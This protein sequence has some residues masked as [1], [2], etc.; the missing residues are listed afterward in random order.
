[1]ATELNLTSKHNECPPCLSLGDSQLRILFPRLVL[2]CP[3]PEV[4]ANGTTL[5]ETMR[6]LEDQHVGHGGHGSDALDLPQDF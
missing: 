4:G 6:I 5:L 2:P 1:M 3:Q